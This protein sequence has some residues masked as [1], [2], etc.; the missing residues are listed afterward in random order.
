MEG[1]AGRGYWGEAGTW[2]QGGACKGVEARVV[3]V[4]QGWARG[5]GRRWGMGRCSVA[6]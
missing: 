2:Q 4:C 3:V 5:Q 6:G 1:S